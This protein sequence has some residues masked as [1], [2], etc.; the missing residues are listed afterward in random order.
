MNLDNDD[1][2][3]NEEY[4]ETQHGKF[5]EFFEVPNRKFENQ[6]GYFTQNGREFSDEDGIRAP[7]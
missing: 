2:K 6:K 7:P 4:L 1:I 3:I 5:D